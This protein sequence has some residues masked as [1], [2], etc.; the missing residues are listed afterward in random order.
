MNYINS[1]F[2]FVLILRPYWIHAKLIPF[3]V[4]NSEI[5][6][7]FHMKNLHY[8]TIL[9]HYFVLYEFY[10]KGNYWYF[11]TN[12]KIHFLMYVVFLKMRGSKCQMYFVVFFG[13]DLAALQSLFVLRFDNLGH[14]KLHKQYLQRKLFWSYSHYKVSTD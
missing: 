10:R 5:D 1:C 14:V 13:W 4:C 8:C 11:W 9:Y 7:L 6:L 12:V 2:V 3:R